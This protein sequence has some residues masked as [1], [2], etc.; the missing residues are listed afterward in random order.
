MSEKDK[1]IDDSDLFKENVRK[2]NNHY[3]LMEEIKEEFK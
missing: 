2:R 1:I 3:K